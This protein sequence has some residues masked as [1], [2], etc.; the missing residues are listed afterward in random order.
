MS[1]SKN[2]ATTPPSSLSTKKVR[3]ANTNNSNN[4][5][6]PVS[7]VATSTLDKQ[8]KVGNVSVNTG[9]FRRVVRGPFFL[10]AFVLVFITTAL[11]FISLFTNNWQKTAPGLIDGQFFTY[12]LWFTCRNLRVSWPSVSL[13]NIYCFTS[14]YYLG[15]PPKDKLIFPLLK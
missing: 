1:E 14:E 8:P 7:S 13:S 15:I 5:M 12:G 3:L 4:N 9:P 6:S 11:V 2:G 10:M